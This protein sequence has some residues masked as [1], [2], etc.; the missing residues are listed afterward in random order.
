VK[1]VK[2]IM[3]SKGF[4]I[5]SATERLAG[6]ARMKSDL[7]SV[8]VGVFFEGIYISMGVADGGKAPASVRPVQSARW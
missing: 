1:D 6:C 2:D 4:A 8:F 5:T 7:E 3:R